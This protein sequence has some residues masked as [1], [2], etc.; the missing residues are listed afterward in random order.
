MVPEEKR[1]SQHF[2]YKF[3]DNSLADSLFSPSSKVDD[4]N[5]FN[6]LKKQHAMTNS[7]T[8]ITK[9]PLTQSEIYMDRMLELGYTNRETETKS[10]FMQS[11]R[12]TDKSVRDSVMQID[13]SGG[14][15]QSEKVMQ[16][17]KKLQAIIK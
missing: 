3:I 11:G 8:S 12:Y 2:D 14:Y 6:L 15:S 10:K 5:S 4:F 17:S 1:S 13:H 16:P 9:V 7:Q